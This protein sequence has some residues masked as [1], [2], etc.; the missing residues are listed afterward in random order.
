MHFEN[1]LPE[2][3]VC[4][5]DFTCALNKKGLIRHGRMYFTQHYVCFHSPIANTKVLLHVSQIVSVVPNTILGFPTAIDVETRDETL[6]FVSFLFRS[7][8][9]NSFA[10]ILLAWR[11]M[12][13]SGDTVDD[14]FTQSL[15]YHP[16]SNLALPSKDKI[17]SDTLEKQPVSD[18]WMVACIF[19]VTINVLVLLKSTLLVSTM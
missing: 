17:S 19:L 9:L 5:A 2:D 8:A 1:R 4:I 10:T 16:T 7:N 3:E 12:S 13:Q 18:Y 6:N 11:K 14:T 15:E